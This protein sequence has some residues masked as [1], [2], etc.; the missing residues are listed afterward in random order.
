LFDAA[1][2]KVEPPRR[3]DAARPETPLH[4]A[5]GGAAEDAEPGGGDHE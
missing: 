2:R 4:A 5:V 3:R 1:I